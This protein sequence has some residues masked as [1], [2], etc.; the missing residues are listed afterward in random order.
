MKDGLNLIFLPS[1]FHT[2][3]EVPTKWRVGSRDSDIMEKAKKIKCTL[4]RTLLQTS[5]VAM[6]KRGSDLAFSSPS[7][8]RSALPLASPGALEVRRTM[9]SRWREGFRSSFR[10]FQCLLPYGEAAPIS[11]SQNK[12][13]HI[14]CPLYWCA[15]QRW[16]VCGVV[17]PSDLLGSTR[18][19]C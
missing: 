12:V 3:R 4:E 19:S 1:L 6:E 13:L 15:Y 5:I 8:P 9:T 16:R 18:F 11:W 2:D 14:Q 17:F 10:K 7:C